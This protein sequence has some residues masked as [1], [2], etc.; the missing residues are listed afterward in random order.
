MIAIVDCNNFFVSCERVFNPSLQNKPVVVLSNNDG[1]VVAM[2]DEAKN[3]G[4]TRGV[5][6]YSIKSI[7]E[8]YKVDV[9]SSN[10][11]LYG[12]MSSRVM[13]ILS[14]FSENVEIYSIDE[15]FLD[16]SNFTNDLSP[17]GQEIIKTVYKSTGIPVSIGIAPTKTLAKVAVNYA[18]K[19]KE[20]QSVYVIDSDNKRIKMLKS[21]PINK[22]WGIGKSMSEKL[23]KL[24]I[25]SAY[26]FIS[27]SYNQYYEILNSSIIN[28]WRELKGVHSLKLEPAILSTQS[29]CCSRSFSISLLE[30]NEIINVISQFAEDVSRKLVKQNSG[31]KS[32]CVFV[33]TNL[34]STTELQYSN[35]ATINFDVPTSDAMQ[36]AK[37]A[38]AAIDSIYRNGY[39]YKKVGIIITEIKN[40]ESN[41]LNM[42]STQELLF[43]RNQ[44]IKTINKI[45]KTQ[46]TINKVRVAASISNKLPIRNNF[47]SRRYTTN[48]EDIIEI[49]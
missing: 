19:Q 27:F 8:K 49:N 38:I 18:K 37:G 45:N 11:R 39:I 32:M 48:F 26:D 23:L 31:A 15:A 5:P 43:K 25:N 13:A 24:G 3:L 4:I 46:T 41:Q 14:S 33:H 47:L 6:Q 29:I 40:I 42:Y 44:L 22:V 16:L 30:K 36:I 1:C 9:Y 2:S 28:T 17:F 34:Y 20:H 21:T 10:Y 7:I 12:D 35:S